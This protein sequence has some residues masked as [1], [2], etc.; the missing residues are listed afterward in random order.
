MVKWNRDSAPVQAALNGVL[1]IAEGPNS[2]EVKLG[3]AELRNGTAL[4]PSVGPNVRFR[5]E[6]FFKEN[7][8]FVESTEFR[9]Q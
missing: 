7:R 1:T 6:L 8:S 9:A 2:K 5:L 3:F 4:Y